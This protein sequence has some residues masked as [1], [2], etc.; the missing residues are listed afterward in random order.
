MTQGAMPNPVE[1]FTKASNH[2]KG[3]LAGVR[4]EQLDGSTPCSEWNV[5]ALIDHLIG[6]AQYLNSSLSGNPSPP[7]DAGGSAPSSGNNVAELA[8]TYGSLTA[9][10]L[11]AAANPAALETKIETP[12]G[13]MSGG[14]FLGIMFM[15]HLVHSWD[16]AKATGQD[17]RLDAELAE[18]CYQMCTP[19]LIEMGRERGAFGPALPVPESA[20][21]QDKLLGYMGRQPW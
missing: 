21:T 3:V 12:V 13:E 18:I 14:Q 9:E 10:A 17:T 20:S 6:G 5:K 16:L 2:A 7:G 19:S 1:L 4:Q 8:A 15:D 11:R